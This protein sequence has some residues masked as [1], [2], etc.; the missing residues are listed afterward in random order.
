MQTSMFLIDL[1]L[2]LNENMCGWIDMSIA[3]ASGRA[4]EAKSVNYI[5]ILYK[6][7]CIYLIYRHYIGWVS[8][9]LHNNQNWGRIP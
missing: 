3:D 8:C 9:V 7:I 4:S 1:A 2:D 6:Y 5:C